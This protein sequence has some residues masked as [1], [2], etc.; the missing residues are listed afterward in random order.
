M[1]VERLPVSPWEASSDFIITEFWALHWFI[2]I[3]QLLGP[4]DTSTDHS[5][6]YL[7]AAS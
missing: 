1:G 7:E 6:S 4:M 5:G 3:K 2:H